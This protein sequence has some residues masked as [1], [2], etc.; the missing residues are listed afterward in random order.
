MH[1]V[2]FLSSLQERE[3]ALL[4]RTKVMEENAQLIEEL[5]GASSADDMGVGNGSREKGARTKTVAASPPAP[6]L[7]K[8]VSFDGSK[9]SHSS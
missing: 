3:D 6:P 5:E 9:V 4:E 7:A 1:V 8:N 2:G